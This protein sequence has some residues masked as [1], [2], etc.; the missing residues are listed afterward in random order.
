MVLTSPDSLV[1]TFNLNSGSDFSQFIELNEF[2]DFFES[3]RP[4]CNVTSYR[5]VKIQ[6]TTGD[7]LDLVDDAISMDSEF[8]ISVNT[9]Y[10]FS[11]SVLIEASTKKSEKTAILE[12]IVYVTNFAP[13]FTDGAPELQVIQ[14]QAEMTLYEF[15][16]P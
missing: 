4:G 16:I 6:Y 15:L 14:L 5:L 2:E 7:V 10:V 13:Y 8:E 9:S 1:K 11:K 3:S 12:L